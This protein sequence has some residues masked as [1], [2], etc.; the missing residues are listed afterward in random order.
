MRFLLLAV[1]WLFM[2]IEAVAQNAEP[3]QRPNV[4]FI[5]VDDMGYSDIG[6]FGGEIKTPTL[7][8]LADE[9]VRLSNFHVLPSCSPTRA[10]MLTGA[11]NHRVGIGAQEGLATE[12]Q[13]GQP[14]YEMHL[15]DRAATLAEILRDGGYRTYM[16][17]KW[18]LGKTATTIPHGK[19]FER[20]FTLLN[21]GGS[22]WGDALPSDPEEPLEYFHDDKLVET[23]PQDFYSSRTY[24]DWLLR[25]LEEDKSS[26]KPFFAYLSFTAPHDPLH[27]PEVYINKYAGVYDKG[28]EELRKQRFESLKTEGLIP[29]EAPLPSWEPSIKRWHELSV[30]EQAASA[31]DMQIYAGMIDYVDGQIG[32]VYQWLQARGEL[33]NTLIIFMSD[34][35]A[36]AFPSAYFGDDAEFLN[37]F[38]NSLLNRGLPGSRVTMGPGWAAASTVPYRLFKAFT[39][40]GGIRTPAIVRLPQAVAAATVKH[41]FVHVRDLMPTTLELAKVQHPS[42]SN[43]QLEKMTGASILDL[44]TA[45]QAPE[46]SANGIGYEANGNRA[47]IHGDWKLV[48]LVV[49]WGSGEWE[50]YNLK[51]DIS[52]SNNLALTHPVKL[53]DMITRYYAYEEANGVI[54]DV[55]PPLKIM[56]RAVMSASILSTLMVMGLMFRRCRRSGDSRAAALDWGLLALATLGVV[57]M[58]SYYGKYAIILVAAVLVIDMLDNIRRRQT[59]VYSTLLPLLALLLVGLVYFA[60]SGGLLS[61]VFYR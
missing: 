39:T 43:P 55:I 3:L 51:N 37:Q 49:P 5:V 38:D 52:E 25:F 61:L 29:E 59:I 28:Y 32:R 21:G 7:D 10:V 15:N 11:D 4:L 40:E 22:H 42:V 36:S 2:S 44:L 12:R 30:E 56:H 13:T 57:G 17:G 50:L 31:R 9:G 53:R 48:Q 47:Y 45:E 46:R 60:K 27:A 18:H 58:Y 35:G 19:G 16:T 34:N 23:L 1:V 33:E 26:E 54:H 14:G 6:P 41:D 24:T 8:R 20:S